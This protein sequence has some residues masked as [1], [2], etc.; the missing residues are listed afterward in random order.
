MTVRLDKR[1]PVAVVT[2][3][4]PQVRNA[5]DEPSVDAL[6]S[7]LDAL[8]ADEEI[9]V[10]VLTGAGDRTFCAGGDLD[11]FATLTTRDEGRAMS[12]RMRQVTARLADGPRV[13]VVAANGDALGGG[14]ELLLCG[15]VRVA[16]ATARFAFRQAAMGVVTGW[17][18]GVRALRNLGTD[19]ARALWLTG[20]ELDAEQAL[21]WGLVHALKEPGDVL[22]RAL[23]IAGDIAAQGAGAVRAFLRIARSYE[24][25][26]ADAA[27]AEEL[28]SF[29]ELW[30]GERFRD[31]LADWRKRP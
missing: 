30:T 21:R 2:L 15:H 5:I 11:W 29:T 25:D 7:H 23:A 26:G 10:V 13:L 4:R 3:D 9:R 6:E 24:R 31:K 20:E 28:R 17:G 16:S 27:S 1:G 8:D 12:R 14:M 18:G 22:P 19:R